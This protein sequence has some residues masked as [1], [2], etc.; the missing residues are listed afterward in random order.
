MAPTPPLPSAINL[1]A[2]NAVPAVSFSWN[3]GGGGEWDS[4]AFCTLPFL[5][6]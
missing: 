5:L 3:W 2:W 4:Q 6:H 1:L